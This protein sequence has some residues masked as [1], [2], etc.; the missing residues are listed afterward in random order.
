[1]QTLPKNREELKSMLQYMRTQGA[2]DDELRAAVQE[3]KTLRPNVSFQAT[4]FEQTSANTKK[5]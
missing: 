2:N 5:S 3:V 4:V 1:M